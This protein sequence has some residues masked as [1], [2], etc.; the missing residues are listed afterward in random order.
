VSSFTDADDGGGRGGVGEG[1]AV[2]L[3]RNG[4][5]EPRSATVV[6]AGDDRVVQHASLAPG[7]V[8]VVSAPTDGPV[9]AEVHAADASA[10]LSFDPATASVPPLFALREG[11]VLL[12]SV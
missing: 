5:T 2:V 11:R 4:T 9:V 3:L 7:E 10:S 6:L 8:G 1:R 12:A